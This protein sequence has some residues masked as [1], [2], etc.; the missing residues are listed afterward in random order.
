MKTECS[1]VR[2]L[3]PLYVEDMVSAETAAYINE[4]LKVCKECQAE[5]ANM[6]DGNEIPAIEVK[7][8]PK[9]KDVKPF[10]KLMI[11]LFKNKRGK[12]ELK[13]NGKIS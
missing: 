2:D 13:T 9:S 7:S 10:K 8:P 5:L 4:H 1:L 6:K 11:C 3:L 12:G